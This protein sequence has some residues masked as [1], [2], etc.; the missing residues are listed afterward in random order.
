MED[1]IVAISTALGKGAISI[2]RLSG[3]DALRIVNMSFK[4]DDL[5]ESL[6]NTI[7]YGHIVNNNEIVDEVLVSV[8]KA[9]KTYTKEDIVEI[10]CHGGS[11]VT[12][13]VLQLMILNGARLAEPGE[14]TKRAFLNGRIDLAQ[15][16]S[17]MDVI[18]AKTKSSLKLA[19]IGLSGEISSLIK[20]FREEI[21][22]CILKIEVNI[23]YP[24]YEDEE[25]IT[26]DV[27]LPLLEKLKYEL[28][29]IIEKSECSIQIKEGIDTAIV[30]RP[31]VGKSSLLNALLKE[32]KAIVTSTPGTTRDI[33]E[34]KINLGGVILNLIDTAGIR[35]TD[36]NIER[37]GIE[38]SLDA[39]SK[40]DLI[41]LMFDYN[42]KLTKEDRELLD[43]TKDKNRIIIINK[44][45]LER[46]IELS[47]LNNYLLMS[48]FNKL[49]IE[50]LEKEIKTVCE[51][52]DV[53]LLDPTYLGNARQI[54]KIKEA[55]KAIL[56][57]IKGTNAHL[58]TD[59]IN[60]DL[61]EAW[62]SLGEI[63]GEVSGE[64][65]VNE[66]FAKF[67]LGK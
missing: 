65:I 56:N 19:N 4:G 60:I 54:G 1:T 57:A 64:E 24:E 18:E 20:A 62:K 28:E 31:N 42:E 7:H 43:K 8:F 66:L 13:Q 58:P 34:G 45:D 44:N 12:N 30:G 46:K 25:Q 47:D 61:R 55:Y 5:E 14:F 17:V 63:L 9:P 37:I 3:I 10:N 32:N 39:I 50:K 15:A 27:I 51:I 35:K 29:D 48:A 36:D 2:V 26:T 41:L 38:K 49:D 6:P 52:T 59:I 16:E 40:A 67:C 21:L 23:D 22:S 53:S 33:V 11:Y